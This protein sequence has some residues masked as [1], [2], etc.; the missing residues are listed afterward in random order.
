MLAEKMKEKLQPYIDG[1]RAGF[2]MQVLLCTA[3]LCVVISRN[4]LCVTV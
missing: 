1:D 2:R 3:V 4:Q